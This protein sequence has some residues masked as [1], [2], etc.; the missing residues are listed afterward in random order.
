MLQYNHMENEQIEVK[1]EP[2]EVN[3]EEP[4]IRQIV[5]ETDGNM[6]RITKAEVAGD[7][8]L[9]AIFSILLTHLKTKK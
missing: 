7:I 1:N 5:V 9:S 8:E 4:K 6:V 2:V 3:H